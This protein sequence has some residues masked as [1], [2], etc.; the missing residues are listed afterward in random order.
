[1]L[2]TKVRSSN[3]KS[4]GYDSDEKLLEVEFHSGRIYQYSDVPG[5]AVEKLRL[6]HSVGRYFNEVIRKG[7]KATEVT[8]DDEQEQ[9]QDTEPDLTSPPP[10]PPARPRVIQKTQVRRMKK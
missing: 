1:M 5:M 2:R 3:I 4:I 9:N 10:T 6:A 8:E 7:F